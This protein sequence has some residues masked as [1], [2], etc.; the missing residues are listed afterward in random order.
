ML[1]DNPQERRVRLDPHIAHLS[2]DIEFCHE[3]PPIP[4]SI[5]AGQSLAYGGSRRRPEST[6]LADLTFL[7]KCCERMAWTGQN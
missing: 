6:Q 4:Q 2:I 3:L 1:P 5:A 7:T